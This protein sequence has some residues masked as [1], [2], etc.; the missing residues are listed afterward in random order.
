MK[1]IKNLTGAALAFT[2]LFQPPITLAGDND[3]RCDDNERG[4]RGHHNARATFTKWVTGAPNLPGLLITLGGVVGG[5]V[6]DG[7]FTGEVLFRAPSPTGN[8]IVAVYHFAGRKHSFTA[9][10][11]VVQTG[12][13]PG[14]K[15]VIIGAVTDGWLKGSLVD[16]T[17]TEIVA[18]HDGVTSTAYQGVLEIGRN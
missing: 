3:K 11:D 13:G 17:Y 10:L 2:L 6:G 4:D 8:H 1:T 16:G 12:V 14:T 7:T 15:A 18:V 9:L 5:D